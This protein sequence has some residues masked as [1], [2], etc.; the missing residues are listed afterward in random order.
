MIFDGTLRGNLTRAMSVFE[1]YGAVFSESQFTVLKKVP[2]EELR[3]VVYLNESGASRV[4]MWINRLT[5]EVAQE[6]IANFCKG[7]KEKEW[8][9]VT[10]HL[11]KDDNIFRYF[12]E[13]SMEGYQYGYECRMGK[14]FGSF[15]YF[16]TL[17][18]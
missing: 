14:D 1:A 6:I 12:L 3:V 13:F 11:R 17:P 18:E 4:V 8:K 10:E 5:D 7:D 15:I 2:S 9:S 16:E